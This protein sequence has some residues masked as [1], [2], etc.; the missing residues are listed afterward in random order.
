MVGNE[1]AGRD[2]EAFNQWDGEALPIAEVPLPD[3]FPV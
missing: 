2:G 3:D 1:H